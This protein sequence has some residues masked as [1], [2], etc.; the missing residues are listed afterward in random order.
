MDVAVGPCDDIA[1]G[2]VVAAEE[3]N[4]DVASAGIRLGKP[5][6]PNDPLLGG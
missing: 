5:L 1:I 2:V 4:V 6:P 3:L